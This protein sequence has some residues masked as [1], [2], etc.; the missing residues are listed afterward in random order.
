MQGIA[1][2]STNQ[3]LQELSS[4]GIRPGEARAIGGLVN[5]SWGVNQNVTINL[6][7]GGQVALSK[8]TSDMGFSIG[9]DVGLRGLPGSL[10]SGDNGYLGTAEVVWTVWRPSNQ[11]VQLIPF[12]GM[13]GVQTTL[14]NVSVNDSV[15]SGGILA[16]WLAGVNW[17][18]E[19]GWVEQ[20]NAGD[21]PGFWNDWLLGSGLYSKVQ[22]R[23]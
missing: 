5:L 14:D 19:L 6:R 17:S 22:Y 1:G 21:N 15:G 7:G 12:L 13:G 4:F 16:R 2:F 20:F 23:F 11:A 10:I 9:S 8:L 3:H 18:V